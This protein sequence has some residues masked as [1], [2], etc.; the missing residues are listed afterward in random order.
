MSRRGLRIAVGG[1]LALCW[2]AG[3]PLRAGAIPPPYDGEW[4]C[5]H[6]W[7]AESLSHGPVAIANG[8][9][10]PFRNF[11][12]G[13][14]A[15]WPGGLLAPFSLVAGVFQGS[16]LIALGAFETLTGGALDTIPPK[17]AHFN[18]QPMVQLPESRRDYAYEN[19]SCPEIG[20]DRPGADY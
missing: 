19:Y 9:I 17:F 18:A 20:D 10:L 8:A 15:G 11:A 3:L 4:P 16:G 1:A 7:T 14:R 5:R 6:A 2:L 12:S 13:F